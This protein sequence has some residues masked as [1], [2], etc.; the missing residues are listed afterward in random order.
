VEVI[1]SIITQNT[2]A[3]EFM[4]NVDTAAV[5]H[6]STRFTD[7]G[8]FGLGELPSVQTSCIKEANWFTAPGYQ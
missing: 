2:V 7:G 3:Q 4:E 5:Y 8:Q 1:P 6:A